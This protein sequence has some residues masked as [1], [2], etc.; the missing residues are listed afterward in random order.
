MSFFDDLPEQ[1]AR[2]RE[3]QPAQP[4]WL[5]PPSDELPGIARV[6]GFVH[7][8]SRTV[9]VLKL[10]EVYSTGCLFDLVW[11]VRRGT[12]SD[13]EWRE[14][15]EE[16]YNHPRSSLDT[17]TGL[18]LG[19]AVADGRKAVSAI[20]GP[21]AFEDAA[22]TGPVLTTL[23]GGGGSNNSEFVQFTGRYWLWPLPMEDITLVLRWEALGIPESS[24]VLSGEQL[25]EAL[26]DAQKYWDQ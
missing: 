11:S 17:R 22:V 4:G 1:P 6:G 24:L 26:A 14:M 13:Q 9:V 23:G 15:V 16:S 20:N 18:E 3:P 25:A 8:D 10:V 19:V 21:A 5:G 7:K 2:P 12:E